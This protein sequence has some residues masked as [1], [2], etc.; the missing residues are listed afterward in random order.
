MQQAA[1]INCQAAFF[2]LFFTD[3][4]FKNRAVGIGPSLRVVA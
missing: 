1:D 4:S 3:R 2:A